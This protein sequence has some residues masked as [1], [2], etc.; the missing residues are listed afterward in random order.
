M[1]SLQRHFVIQKSTI[2]TH[3]SESPHEWVTGIGDVFQ[4]V[5][6]TAQ[7]RATECAAGTGGGFPNSLGMDFGKLAGACQKLLG[8]EVEVFDPEPF[9]MFVVLI[10]VGAV[11]LE[12]EIRSLI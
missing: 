2:V 3:Q 8:L 6:E 10:E 11:A 5:G 4:R 12:P 9:R 1:Q 7:L